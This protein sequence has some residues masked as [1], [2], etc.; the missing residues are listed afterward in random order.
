[1][2][3]RFCKT[4]RRNSINCLCRYNMNISMFILWYHWSF[5]ADIIFTLDSCCKKDVY[6]FRFCGKKN[7]IHI[8]IPFFRLFVERFVEA[9]S[10][11]STHDIYSRKGNFL[12]SSKNRLYIIIYLHKKKDISECFFIYIYSSKTSLS[13]LK[14]IYNFKQKITKWILSVVNGIYK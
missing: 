1:M 6:V 7:L 2:Y 11:M 12:N 13:C 5:G 4:Q 14:K 9:H 10:H 8:I 3:G